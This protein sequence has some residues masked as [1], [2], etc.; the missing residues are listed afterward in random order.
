MTTYIDFHALQ[1]LAPN[2]INRGEDG[3]PK[4][5]FFGGVQRQRI[6][7]QALKAAQRR[8]FADYLDR[9]ELGT[10]TKRVVGWSLSAWWRSTP[11]Q[12]TTMP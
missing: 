5:A 8:S 9:S 1:T 2:N 11:P 4:T 10:R 12:T 7:S 3:A 6:S